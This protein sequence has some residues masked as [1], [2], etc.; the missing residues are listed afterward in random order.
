MYHAIENGIITK[1]DFKKHQDTDGRRTFTGKK[2]S[3][4]DSG[5]KEMNQ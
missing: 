1:N 3:D 4:K 5:E 2:E